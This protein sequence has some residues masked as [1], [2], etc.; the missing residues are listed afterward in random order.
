MREAHLSAQNLGME[1][2][3]ALQPPQAPAPENNALPR[4]RITHHPAVKQK[5][6]RLKGVA[7]VAQSNMSYI[8]QEQI[9]SSHVSEKLWR[10][11]TGEHRGAV[12]TVLVGRMP[13]LAEPVTAMCGQ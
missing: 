5:T 10:E 3:Q 6:S 9:L 11:N 13:L 1:P 7:Q 8:L 12:K 2:L 4:Q